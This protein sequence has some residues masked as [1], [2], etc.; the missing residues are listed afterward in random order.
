MMSDLD[1]GFLVT[2]GLG[3]HSGNDPQGAFFVQAIGFHIRSG[4]VVGRLDRTMVSG[5]V[6][7]DLLDVAALSRD[8]RSTEAMLLGNVRAPYVLVESLQV[9][10]Q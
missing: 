9:A 8:V 7:K 1:K 10:G 6:Y 2:G 4:R 5:N 3:F